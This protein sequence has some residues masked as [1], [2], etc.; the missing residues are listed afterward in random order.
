MRKGIFDSPTVVVL[1]FAL[2]VVTGFIA[3]LFLGGLEPL[4]QAL[5]DAFK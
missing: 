2:G 1:I 3:S 5:R 4:I